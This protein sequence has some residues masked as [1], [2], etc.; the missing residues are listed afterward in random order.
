MKMNIQTTDNSIGDMST[1]MI[2]E[3]TIS[4][5]L[6]SKFNFK[7]CTKLCEYGLQ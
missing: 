1:H 4:Y 5:L 6:P 2:L 7:T 3:L